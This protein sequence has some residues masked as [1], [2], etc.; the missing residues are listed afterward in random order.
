[1]ARH[2]HSA[3]VCAVQSVAHDVDYLTVPSFVQTPN[4]LPPAISPE[5][6][7]ASLAPQQI[8]ELIAARDRS[9]KLRRAVGVARFDAWM[10]AVFA[11]LTGLT[12]LL[13]LPSV[14][15]AAGMGFVAW[16]EFR[17]AESLRRLDPAAARSLA[18][19][20]LCLAGILIVYALFQIYQSYN[21]AGQYTAMAGGDAQLAQMLGPID[22][23][24]KLL[25]ISVYGLIILI[26]IVV[27]GGTA[28][29]YATRQRHLR[30]YLAQT[31]PWIRDL[32]QRGISI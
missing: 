29:Y 6:A 12:G 15:L 13:D 32:Q 22:Q 4:R 21:R 27:Q 23:L 18:L 31:P 30:Q 14:L 24:V 19:N 28:L 5:T 20:Q 7:T 8:T 16:R 2:H 9:A 17:G 11:A 10:I 3:A 26:A 1:V 25:T